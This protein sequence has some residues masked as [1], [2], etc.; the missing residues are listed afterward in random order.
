MASKLIKSAV[1]VR[2]APDGSVKREA[3]AG[4]TPTR[5][6]RG[7]KRLRGVEKWI[8]KLSRATNE[9]SRVYMSGHEASN[10]KKK[11]GWFK[12][13]GKNMRKANR[14]GM[15]VLKLRLF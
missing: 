9:T 6:R 2:F 4:A 11:N 5:K 1:I 8:R 14:R 3:L 15:K 12:D 10:Q 7:S 13:L